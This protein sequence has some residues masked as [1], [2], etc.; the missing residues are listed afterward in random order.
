MVW[1][2]IT[3]TAEQT[4]F[5]TAIKKAYISYIGSLLKTLMLQ[6]LSRYILCFRV[7]SYHQLNETVLHFA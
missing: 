2:K 3:I 6:A 7:A 5:I 1:R 4:Q